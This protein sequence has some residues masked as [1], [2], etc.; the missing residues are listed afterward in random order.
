MLG[1]AGDLGALEPT[2]MSNVNEETQSEEEK[3]IQARCSKVVDHFRAIRQELHQANCEV[4]KKQ[5]EMWKE[6]SMARR[7]RRRPR[8]GPARAYME[9]LS[10]V[11]KLK[12]EKSLYVNSGTTSNNSGDSGFTGHP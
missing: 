3:E 12:V 1:E 10:R 2:C 7:E 4:V 9:A 11:D 6:E 8:P 5:H